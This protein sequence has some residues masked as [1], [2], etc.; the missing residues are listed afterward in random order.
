M[1]NGSFSGNMKKIFLINYSLMEKIAD[2]KNGV[3]TEELVFYI[4]PG[5][6]AYYLELM[7]AQKGFGKIKNG[8]KVIVRVD[9]YPSE[10]FGTLSARINYVS[11]IPNRSDSFALKANLQNGLQTNYGKLILGNNSLTAH[12]DIITD[13]RRLIDRFMGQL[14]QTF[15]R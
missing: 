2:K 7:V 8:Q 5:N 15:K 10:E 13:N 4:Q 12:V 3:T 9:G 14:R 1:V 11:P 6:S